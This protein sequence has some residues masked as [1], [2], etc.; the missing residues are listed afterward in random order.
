MLADGSKD[1]DKCS[2]RIKCLVFVVKGADDEVRTS[3]KRKQ[4]VLRYI[5]WGVKEHKTF[6]LRGRIDKL[7]HR[8]WFDHVEILHAIRLILSAMGDRILASLHKDRLLKVRVDDTDGSAFPSK[9]VGEEDAECA[10]PYPTLLVGKDNLDI[11]FH[12]FLYYRVATKNR[13]R[14]LMF[15]I[16]Y[17]AAGF[18]PGAM[19]PTNFH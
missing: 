16:L 13:H 10:L 5:S 4:S 8:V 3:E 9:I 6:H 1:G 7:T 18:G 14:S 2:R 12:I 15:S 11:F 19:Y 17:V